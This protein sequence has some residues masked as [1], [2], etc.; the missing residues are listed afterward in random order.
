MQ[1]RAVLVGLLLVSPAWGADD[2]PLAA[3]RLEDPDWVVRALT[4]K[5]LGD[6][7]TSRGILWMRDRLEQ[8][9]NQYAQAF[10]LRSLLTFPL[11]DLVRVGQIPLVPAAI[12][13]LGSKNAHV[14]DQARALLEKLT[15]QKAGGKRADWEAWWKA[16]QDG[17][18]FPK[19]PAPA[20]KGVKGVEEVLEVTT[21]KE[22]VFE[23]FVYGARRHGLEVV[24]VLDQ[25]SSMQPAIDAAKSRILEICDYVS[26]LIPKYRVGLVT[27]DDGAVLSFPLTKEYDALQKKLSQVLA[28][29]GGDTPEGVDKG[30]A[31]ALKPGLGWSKQARKVLIVVGDAPPHPEDMPKTVA[32]VKEAVQSGWVVSAINVNLSFET[33]AAFQEIAKAGKGTAVQA[34]V[35]E[36]GRGAAAPSGGE[37]LVEEMLILSLGEEHRKALSGFVAVVRAVRATPP[38]P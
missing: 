37:H 9:Q 7:Q 19:D 36:T 4:A 33:A 2:R 34:P 32:M 21:S 22:T 28:V 8:E 12:K 16:H 31:S 27:Y 3:K 29:G 24:F 30:L 23:E 35:Q 11:K 14:R 18:A 6:T 26:L 38:T 15:G 5:S 17:F 10:I 25:T 13:C 1:C 20:S